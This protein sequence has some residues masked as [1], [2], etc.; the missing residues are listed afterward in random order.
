MEMKKLSFL[1]AALA[2][3]M[4][5][6]TSCLGDGDNEIEVLATGIVFMNDKAGF[7]Q[8]VDIGS[9]YLYIPQL[10]TAGEY[11]DGDCVGVG[12]HVNYDG[13]ENADY[14]TN[15]YLT[16]SLTSHFEIATYYPNYSMD[17]ASVL[18]NEI[19]MVSAF[20]PSQ[21]NNY[22]R[23]RLIFP[24]TIKAGSKQTLD[25]EVMYPMDVQPE[26]KNGKRYYNLYLR[27]TATGDDTGASNVSIVNAYYLK[28]MIDRANEIEKAAGKE[29]YYLKFNFVREIKDDKPVWD[30]EEAGM[31]VPQDNTNTNPSM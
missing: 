30:F 5:L 28:E 15:G 16:A 20:Q 19:P 24:S 29:T 25:F 11:S 3:A 1:A 6:F 17:T 14:M 18:P 7:K 21:L 27:A 2:S 4:S 13:P 10:M 23:G 8:M 9:A 12:V 31:A 26:E 22:V